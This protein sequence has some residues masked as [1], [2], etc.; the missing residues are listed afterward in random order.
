MSRRGNRHRR[1][2]RRLR[3]RSLPDPGAPDMTRAHAHWRGILATLTGRG[4]REPRF[5]GLVFAPPVDVDLAGPSPPDEAA[6]KTE[7]AIVARTLG[8]KPS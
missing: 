6:E 4:L 8:Q 1:R 2:G 5:A 3:D 7:A